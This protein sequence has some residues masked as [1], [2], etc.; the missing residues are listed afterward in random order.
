MRLIAIGKLE[1]TND[2]YFFVAE[3]FWS[4]RIDGGWAGCL[5]YGRN[6]PDFGLS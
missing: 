2:E 5:Y 3:R 1:M 6:K 4:S